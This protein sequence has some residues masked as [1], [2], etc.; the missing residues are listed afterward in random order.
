MSWIAWAWLGVELW[1]RG[2]RSG[3]ATLAAL[4]VGGLTQDVL[5]DLEVIRVLSAWVLLP[6]L[7]EPAAAGAVPG[8]GAGGDEAA[9]AAGV[10]S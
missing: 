4:A 10:P 8:E 3:R 2:G 7:V 9:L 6:V 1:R 5:G